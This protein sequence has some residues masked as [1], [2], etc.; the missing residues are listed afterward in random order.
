VSGC[1]VLRANRAIAAEKASAARTALRTATAA[2]ERGEVDA[3]AVRAA[4][5]HLAL[6]LRVLDAFDAALDGEAT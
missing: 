3:G 2:H 5:A 4:E 6:Q 1:A